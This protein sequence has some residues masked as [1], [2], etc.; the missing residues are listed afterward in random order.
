MIPPLSFG[1][2]VD[3]LHESAN[4]SFRLD[5]M[6]VDRTD[7]LNRKDDLLPF[8]QRISVS[9]QAPERT[10]NEPTEIGTGIA[11]LSQRT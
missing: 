7:F 9:F 10:G 8:F 4:D 3:G 1:V 6:Q 11:M 5:S 2:C